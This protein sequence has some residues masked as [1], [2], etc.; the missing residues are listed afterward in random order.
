LWHAAGKATLKKKHGKDLTVK[1]SG[2]YL[3]EFDVVANEICL[4]YT[5]SRFVPL[6]CTVDV[7]ELLDECRKQMDLVY[8]FETLKKGIVRTL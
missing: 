3:N 7:M 2:N 8:P 1:G 4:G 5:E 6:Q